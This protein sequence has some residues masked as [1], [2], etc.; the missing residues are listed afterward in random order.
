MFIPRILPQT[1]RSRNIPAAK[2]FNPDKVSSLNCG[3]GTV[4]GGSW[5]CTSGYKWM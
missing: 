3:S 1:T 5:G 4:L 2:V